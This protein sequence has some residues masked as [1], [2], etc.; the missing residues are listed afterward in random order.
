MRPEVSPKGST[1][2][3]AWSVREG[4]LGVTAHPAPVS[5]GSSALLRVLDLEQRA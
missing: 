5:P 4:G 2:A 1:I 3:V